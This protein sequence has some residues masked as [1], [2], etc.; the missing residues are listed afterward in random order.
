MLVSIDEEN[1]QPIYLQLVRQIKE[2]ILVGELSVG[3]ELPSVRELGDA[4][5]ISLHT[6]R[7]AYQVLSEAGLLRVR[8]GKKA[9]VTIPASERSRDSL[10]D[11]YALHMRELIVDGLLQGAS[12]EELRQILGQEIAA[13]SARGATLGIR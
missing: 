1:R 10:S 9:R 13:L 2:Q 7:N 12:A 8:L 6:A 4:L 5:G 3:D 11:E